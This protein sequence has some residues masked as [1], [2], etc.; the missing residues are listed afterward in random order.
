MKTIYEYIKESEGSEE[1][2]KPKAWIEIINLMLQNAKGISKETLSNMLKPLYPDRLKKL[3][4]F[5]NDTDGSKF[6]TYQPSD[7]EFIK[8]ENKDK[9][10]NQLADYIINAIIK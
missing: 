10:C 4:G 6:I 1:Q 5:W 9:I 7:D 3:C 2:P 8:E